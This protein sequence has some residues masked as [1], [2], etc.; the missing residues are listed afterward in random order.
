MFKPELWQ[1]HNEYRTIVNTFGR[2]L[3]RNSP[4]YSF[5]SYD[6]ERQKLL[7]LNLDPLTGYIH[8]FYSNGG[9][10]AKK[11]AQILR[12]LILFVLLFN[13]T[14]A[15]TSLTLWVT[16][17]LPNST[18]LT[19]LIGCTCTQELPPLGSYYDF[20]NRFWMGS[21]DHYSRH[22]LLPKGRN[23]KKPDKTLGADGKLEDG[24]TVSCRDIVSD[25]MAGLPASDNPEAAL[26]TI[27]TL[28]AVLPSV[29]LGLVDAKNLTLSGDGTAVVSHSSPYGR[30]LSSC[31]KTCPYR[32]GCSRHYSDPDAT[33]GW[34]SGNETWF[35]GHTLYMLCCRNNC[36]E[37]ELPLLMK[38]T[39]A[40][41]HDSKN[42]LYAI[43]GFGRHLCGLSPKNVC[44]DSAHD[45]IP[46]YE[47]LERWDINALIDINGRAK[48]SP[49][50]LKDI[51]FDKEGHPLCPAGHKMCPWG[52]DPIKDAHKYRCPLKCGRIA[53]CPHAETCSPGNYGRT[54]YIKN[55]GDLRFHPRI[56]RDS[57]EYR[58]IYSERTACER[59]NNRV[60]N[61]YCLQY[62]KIRGKD[63]FSFWAMLIGICIHLDARYK[64]AHPYAG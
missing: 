5:H 44:L 9:R 22:A 64:T 18:A 25:I 40:R 20:M 17:V 55:H 63:H 31:S 2:R 50:A 36:L 35:F 3:S 29:R 39:G 21:R 26:Q 14:P 33:W 43:D 51:T 1:S 23:G 52:N 61:D 16:E 58:Q 6:V 11:Q 19:I 38:F 56:P 60:L 46:T 30:H 32:D 4:K 37:I 15:K 62:L 45:N 41:R 57:E 24:G 7:N 8:R 49:A 13:K 54:V 42:F 48:S 10:P 59:V 12:S 47:L 27:F 28:L 53:S 34:D